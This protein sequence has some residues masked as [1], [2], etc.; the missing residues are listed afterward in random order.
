MH[1]EFLQRAEESPYAD[2]FKRGLPDFAT[3]Y[4]TFVDVGEWLPRRRAALLAHRTQVDPE[5]H[6]MRLPDDDLR[7][8]FPWEEFLLAQSRVDNGVAPGDVED[9]LFAGLRADV[10]EHRS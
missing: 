6:W 9:D 7:R 8:I 1:E 5:G 10:L 2:W 4:T 3:E